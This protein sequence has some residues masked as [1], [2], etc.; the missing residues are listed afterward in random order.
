VIIVAL[1]A[2]AVIVWGAKFFVPSVYRL[3]ILLFGVIFISA[4]VV[5][6]SI[7][8]EKSSSAL[9]GWMRSESLRYVGRISYGLYLYHLP[10]FW[11]LGIWPEDTPDPSP[12]HVLIGV[13][14]TFAAAMLSFSFIERPLLQF[15]SRFRDPEALVKVLHPV[16]TVKDIPPYPALSTRS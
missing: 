14:A 3:P 7:N 15:Q 10:I 1:F 5:L 11:A 12:V 6:L 16:E 4:A 8:L 2:L 13:V 9:A